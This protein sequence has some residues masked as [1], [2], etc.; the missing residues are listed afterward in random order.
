KSLK[1][2]M[3]R[4]LVQQ[5]LDALRDP[6]DPVLALVPDLP[7]STALAIV[8]APALAVLPLRRIGRCGPRI[9]AGIGKSLTH[10]LARHPC[11]ASNP[12]HIGPFAGRLMQKITAVQMLDAN[13]LRVALALLT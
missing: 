12:A 1:I 13:A 9:A 3:R 7:D 11:T 4:A 5:N 8:D 6:Y 2:K 10:L